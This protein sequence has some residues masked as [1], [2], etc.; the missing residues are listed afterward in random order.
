M[1]SSVVS[2]IGRPASIC[3]QCLAEK[4]N[5]IMSS[6]LKPPFFLWD[7]T[8]WPSARKN[9]ACWSSTHSVLSSHERFESCRLWSSEDR[10]VVGIG[11]PWGFEM[12]YSGFFAKHLRLSESRRYCSWRVR[13]PCCKPAQVERL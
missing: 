12:R 3:C 9:F 4:P 6:W 7:L 2:V 13:T 1:R 11:L 5:E 8:R 10:G